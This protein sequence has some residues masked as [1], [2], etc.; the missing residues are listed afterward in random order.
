MCEIAVQYSQRN[1][2]RRDQGNYGSHLST[3]QLLASLERK[4][5]H[6]HISAKEERKETLEGSDEYI[7]EGRTYKQR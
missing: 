2:S 7:V 3:D 1:M 6:D 4:V 5:T